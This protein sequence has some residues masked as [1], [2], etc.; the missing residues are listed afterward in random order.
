MT[1]KVKRRKT[2]AKQKARKANKVTQFKAF[3]A[4]LAGERVFSNAKEARDLYSKSHFGEPIEGK[5]YYSFVE[6]L[7]LLD[8]KKIVVYDGK[9]KLSHEAF[10]ER[11]RKLEPNFW[12]RY[13]VFRDMRARGYIIKTALKFGADFRVYA[14]GKRPG[15]EHAKWILYPVYE[16][17]SLTWHEFAAKN[18]VAHSTKKNLL[19]GI[20]DDEGDVTYYEVAWTRP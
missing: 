9:K 11:A 5:I 8:A 18:R 10:T 1:K 7:Y 15:Q 2:K 19:I 17:S 12:T 20:V 16:S 4:A 6:A 13:C 14:R 3:K